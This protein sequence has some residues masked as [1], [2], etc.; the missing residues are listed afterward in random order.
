[1]LALLIAAC[2]TSAQPA[3]QPMV[4]GCP[5]H[6][7]EA[8]SRSG[9]S[10]DIIIRVMIAESG[11]NPRAISSKGAIGCMQIMP[12][13]WNYLSMRYGLG[14]DPFDARRNMIGGAMY[15]AELATRYGMA[16]AIAAYNAGPGRYERYTAGQA[17]LPAETVAY[18]ARIGTGVL[19]PGAAVTPPRW[20]E[21]SLFLMAPGKSSPAFVPT[22]VRRATI[23]RTVD[24]LFPLAKM[25]DAG[26]EPRAAR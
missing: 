25:A 15:L 21:A 6:A 18:A 9:L 11:G 17:A 4:N 22:N 13:T 12:E 26:S 10:V 8:A 3:R 24:P 23:R 20:Q 5:V 19:P 1:M 16:G 14:A 2:P 7:A